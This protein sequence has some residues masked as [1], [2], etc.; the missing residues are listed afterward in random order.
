MERSLK[1]SS[2]RLEV[3]RQRTR[4]EQMKR[5]GKDVERKVFRGREKERNRGRKMVRNGKERGER[6]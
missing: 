5:G 3:K 1:P 4:Q 6:G 2:G